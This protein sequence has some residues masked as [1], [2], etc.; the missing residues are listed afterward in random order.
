VSTP[1]TTATVLAAIP[2]GLRTPLLSAYEEIV[3]NYHQS[4]WEPSELNGGKLCEIVYTILR[5]HVDGKYAAKPSG[6]KNMV[7]ASR[8]F[9]QAPKTFPHS[10]RILMP[11]MIVA[12]FDVRNNRGVGHAGGDVDPN[13]MDAVVVL[14]LAKWLMAELVRLFHN[15][16]TAAATAIVDALVEREVPMVWVVNG[17]TKRILNPKMSRPDKTQLLLYQTAGPVAEETLRQWVE[18]PK[19]SEYRKDVLRP[20]HKAKRIEYDQ[21][22]GIVYLSPEG[23]RYVENNLPLTA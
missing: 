22:A 18:H 2:S 13:H 1:P 17:A 6:P 14:N 16:D 12:L 5:G 11:R 3:V 15:V 9:E 20:L 21:A 7:D 19:L 10:V 23:V 4:R 8:A